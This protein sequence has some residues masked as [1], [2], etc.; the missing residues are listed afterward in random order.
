MKNLIITGIPRSGTTLTTAIVDSYENTVGISEPV[1]QAKWSREMTDRKAYVQCLVKDFSDIRD[2]VVNGG[3]IQDRRSPAGL[4]NTNYYRDVDNA[5]PGDPRDLESISWEGMN[6][7][8]ILA[9]KHN[10][11][12]TCVLPDLL[13]QTNFAVLAV[14]RHPVPTILS[15]RALNI[16]ISRGTMPAAEQFWPEVA[17]IRQRTDDLLRIQVELYGLFCM[18]YQLLR[19]KIQLI[20]YEQL[21]RNPALLSEYLG[22]NYVGG[23]EIKPRN[24]RS[25]HSQ[26]EIQEVEEYIKQYCPI[27]F[28]YYPD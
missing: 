24:W 14:I 28:E 25:E 16:P 9:M 10:A 4:V 13:E 27:A 6:S 23:I 26:L 18:R 5:G 7:D 15:W 19:E 1:W 20:R 8:F 2:K 12:Y 17:E 21:I 3:S 11:H 22:R